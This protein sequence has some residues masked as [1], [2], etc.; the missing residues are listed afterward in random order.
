MEAMVRKDSVRPRVRE[1]ALRVAGDNVCY[2]TP[3]SKARAILDTIRAWALPTPSPDG[4]Q[5]VAFCA[6]PPRSQAIDADVAAVALATALAALG[7][8]A[9]LRIVQSTGHQCSV[10]VD[11]RQ[12]PEWITFAMGERR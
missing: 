6:F 11:V 7:L 12:G 5:H 10:A 1:W 9:K 2:P 8:E 3:A 4:A